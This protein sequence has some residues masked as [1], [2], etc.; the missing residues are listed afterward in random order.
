MEPSLAAKPG[1]SGR[2]PGGLTRGRACAGGRVGPR[3]RSSAAQD[4][5]HRRPSRRPRVRL[6][7]H[8]RPLHGPGPR[9]RAALP[10]QRRVARTGK[11]P[12]GPDRRGEEGVRD[13]Q[14]PA[15]LRRADRRRGGRRRAPITRRSGSSW[16][17][18][19]PRRSSPTGRSTTT[20]TTA[21]C[22]CSSTT[23]GCGWARASPSTTT[24]S[25]TART[26]CS[27]RPTHYVDIT[28]TE[29]RKRQACYAHAS[30]A[31]DKFYALQE[32]VTRM[33]GL[34]SGHSAGGG[35]H[36]PR[37]GPGISAAGRLVS[38]LTR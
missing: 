33:R 16:R 28:A 1:V 23:P 21:P 11:T 9:G 32:M 5:R 24:R 17:P 7:R 27:S 8:D 13:P 18:S 6:R 35:V 19:S 10:E 34:E 37:P 15:A 20:P 29:P 4:H 12:E 14:G 25:P 3:R 31:P 36:P 38:L 2:F 22:R 26:P 30:Q